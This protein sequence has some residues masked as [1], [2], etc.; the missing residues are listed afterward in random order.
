[1]QVGRPLSRFHLTTKTWCT[2]QYPF[3]IISSLYVSWI[4]KYLLTG[5]IIFPF[6]IQIKSNTKTIDSCQ[7][8]I[9]YNYLQETWYKCWYN[10]LPKCIISTNP[11]NPKQ[12]Y[13]YTSISILAEAPTYNCQ[14]SN[15]KPAKKP[16]EPV[17]RLKV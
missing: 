2:H 11:F 14:G 4:I 6:F 12:F 10:S 7:F 9:L 8:Y 17:R 5:N 1:M 3:E 16:T 13:K 15:W